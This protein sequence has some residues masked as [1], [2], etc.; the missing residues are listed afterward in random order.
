[1][2]ALEYEPVYM[3]ACK[4]AVTTGARQGELIAATWGSLN[5]GAKTLTI[6]HHWDPIDG[7]VAP[8]DSDTR[9]VNLIGPAVALLEAHVSAE[10]VRGDDELILRAPRSGSH[11]HGKYMTTLVKK[12]AEE[13]GIPEVGEGGRKRRPFHAYRATTQGCASRP[14]ATPSGCRS[15]SGIRTRI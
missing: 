7:L 8:K 6:S 1:M 11:L 2:E 3:L 12:A 9:V 4:L 5:L 10:G 14:A 13:A 15:S